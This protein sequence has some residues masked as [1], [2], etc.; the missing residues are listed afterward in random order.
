MLEIAKLVHCFSCAHV[1]PLSQNRCLSRTQISHGQPTKKSETWVPNW[2][3]AE[4]TRVFPE[5]VSARFPRAAS[6]LSSAS[7]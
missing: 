1:R 3:H 4:I 6:K 5:C 7:I 2:M